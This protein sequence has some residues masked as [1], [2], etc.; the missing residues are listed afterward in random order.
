MPPNIP[1]HEDSAY[2]TRS[3]EVEGVASDQVVKLQEGAEDVDNLTH[4]HTRVAECVER[5]DIGCR[6]A[7]R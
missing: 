7:L 1:T 5:K 4:A 3:S 2:I 6:T